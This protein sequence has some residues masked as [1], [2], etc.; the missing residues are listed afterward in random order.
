M[1]LGVPAINELAHALWKAE[2]ARVPIGTLSERYTSLDEADAYAIAKAKLALRNRRTVGYKLGYTSAAMRQQMNIDHPNYGVLTDDMAVAKEGGAL[3]FDSLIHPLVEPE[4][5][6]QLARDLS[7]G[8][9]DRDS[10]IRA[11]VAVMPAMEICDTRYREYK[12]KAVDNIADN[13]SSAR[14]VLGTPRQLSSS[15][16]LRL[17]EVQLRSAGKLL[18]QGV[19]ANA[20]GDPL[21]AVA[22]LANRLNAEGMTLNAGDVVLTGGLTRGHLAQRGQSFVADFNGLGSVNLHFY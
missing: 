19:G 5:A 2:R 1:A 14:Y 7:G 13:S 21:L 4:I 22:W 9:H 3:A 11:G 15:D 6:V 16:D 12:F 20:L 8:G 17:I 10:V 18:D